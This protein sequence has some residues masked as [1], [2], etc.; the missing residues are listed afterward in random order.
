M[1]TIEIASTLNKVFK[2]FLGL[3]DDECQVI[4]KEKAYFAGGC[5]YSLANEKPVNDYDLFL[6]DVDGVDKLAKYPLWKCKT[7]YALSY[8]KYQIVTKYYGAPE[9]CV[10]QFDFKH[11]MFYYLPG[12]NTISKACENWG[13][14]QSNRL[15]FNSARA[16]DIEG[17]YLRIKKFKKRGFII[18]K[19]LEA[20]IKA[21]TTQKRINAYRK[22]KKFNQA[23]Y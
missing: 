2:K 21:R 23:Y 6:L 16:R 7:E 22:K 1:N 8:G 3:F 14:L 12:S 13:Y 9:D 17:V 10:G 4:L 5:I 11:N 15:V 20:L 18:P 19:G